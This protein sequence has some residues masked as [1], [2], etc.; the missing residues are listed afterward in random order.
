VTF[1]FASMISPRLE[2]K[3]LSY[4]P[5]E[6]S[7]LLIDGRYKNTKRLI[8]LARRDVHRIFQ[9]EMLTKM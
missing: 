7:R 9:S 8:G 1:L 2:I 4:A 5:R 6:R 3:H